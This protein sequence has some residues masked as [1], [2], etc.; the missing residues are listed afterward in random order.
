MESV[1][2]SKIEALAKFLDCEV[3]EINETNYCFEY[4]K[5]EYLVLTDEEAEEKAKEYIL[6]SAWAFNKSF[7]N[8]QSEAIAEMD[9]ETFRV[10]QERC[11]SANKAILAMIDDKDSFVNDAIASDGRGHF[12]SGYD[13]EENEQNGYYIYR[14]N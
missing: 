9:D 14:I 1:K 5:K 13:G 3:E 8:A 2:T 6:D 12:L 11:E 10:I 7:L 4:G